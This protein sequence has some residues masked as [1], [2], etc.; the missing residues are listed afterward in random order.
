MLKALGIASVILAVKCL[1]GNDA[2]FPVESLLKRVVLSFDSSAGVRVDLQFDTLLQMFIAIERDL[3]QMQGFFPC[4]RVQQLCNRSLSAEDFETR[5]VAMRRSLGLDSKGTPASQSRLDLYYRI[6]QE[7]KTK[8]ESQ[9][10]T[11]KEI[12]EA[13]FHENPRLAS[14]IF[15]LESKLFSWYSPVRR[16]YFSF[17]I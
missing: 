7:F 8:Q 15:E 14:N 12:Q 3:L 1:V 13:I 2:K 11:E 4:A 17:I 5:M 6:L 9:K 10:S 16:L